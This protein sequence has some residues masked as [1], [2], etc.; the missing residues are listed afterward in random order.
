M[1]GKFTWLMAV[2]LCLMVYAPAQG[3][4]IDWT[5]DKE[6]V[7]PIS[8]NGGEFAYVP[9]AP[10]YW[11]PVGNIGTGVT[12]TST[13][14]E[15]FYYNESTGYYSGQMVLNATAEANAVG[16]GITAQ[17]QTSITY[18]D[19]DMTDGLNG[20]ENHFNA[21]GNGVAVVQH[22][23]ASLT[24]QFEV[25]GGD[26]LAD[27][28]GV[29]SELDDIVNF[30]E[31]SGPA[32]TSYELEGTINLL[33]FSNKPGVSENHSLVFT[34][35]TDRNQSEEVLL[36]SNEEDGYYYQLSATL[37]VEAEVQNFFYDGGGF[38]TVALDGPFLLGDEDHPVTLTAS[39]ENV[40]PVPV[41]ASFLLLLSGMGCLTL[42]RCFGRK[43]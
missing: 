35:D 11:N 42:W 6:P 23:S 36:H 38:Q 1:K 26:Y 39:L 4:I 25:H 19:I 41:P 20:P 5:I 18:H 14:T 40:R 43:V 2:L 13:K 7:C 22:P 37:W 33:E 32:L 9:G 34:R 30:T 8:S 31:L 3:G 21:N 27:L 12:H 16:D 29:L 15:N 24:R 28:T 10:L 17:V